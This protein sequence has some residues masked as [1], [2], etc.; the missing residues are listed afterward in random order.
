MKV[1]VSFIPRIQKFIEKWRPHLAI[2][3]KT[4]RKSDKYQEM[5]TNLA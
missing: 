3:V 1:L 4:K 2:A 5:S